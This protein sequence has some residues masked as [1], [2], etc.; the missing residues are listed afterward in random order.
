LPEGLPIGTDVEIIL[1]LCDDFYI[2]AQARVPSHDM[3]SKAT[4]ELP[5]KSVRSLAQ[6]REEFHELEPLAKNAMN[7][8]DRERMSTTGPRLHK[9]LETSRCLLNEDPDP[10]LAKV[11]GM[12]DE[13]HALIDELTVWRWDLSVE[14][15]EKLRQAEMQQSA[16]REVSPHMAPQDMEPPQ[17]E[18]FKAQLILALM[19]LK[20]EA[21]SQNLYDELADQFQACDQELKAIGV[22]GGDDTESLLQLVS[23]FENYLRPLEEQCRGNRAMQSPASREMNDT[24][25]LLGKLRGK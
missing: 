14:D 15:F 11:Q 17:P 8:A 22:E 12:L 6:L 19:S 16:T 1:K 2:D 10:T 24:A 18:E 21:R 5:P 25:G 4:I 23:I 7:N 9:I 13:T 20:N 3:T